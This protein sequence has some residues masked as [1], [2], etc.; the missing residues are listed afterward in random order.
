MGKKPNNS[1]TGGGSSNSAATLKRTALPTVKAVVAKIKGASKQRKVDYSTPSF[2]SPTLD[3]F[4]IFQLLV[5]TQSL[6]AIAADIADVIENRVRGILAGGWTKVSEAS[7][8]KQV[9][10]LFAIMQQVTQ[11]T[12]DVMPAKGGQSV[13]ND[14]RYNFI[15]KLAED[16]GVLP[17]AEA[18]ISPQELADMLRLLHADPATLSAEDQA[19][20][21][22]VEQSV[23]LFREHMV[24]QI[25]G[26][27]GDHVIARYVSGVRFSDMLDEVEVFGQSEREQTIIAEL[28]QQSRDVLKFTQASDFEF[29]SDELRATAAELLGARDP[30]DIVSAGERN[31]ACTQLANTLNDG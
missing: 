19:Y 31:L 17:D 15:K 16:T 14:K 8:Y 10:T 25:G 12:T 9:M 26:A 4:T 6:S 24:N 23:N 7:F 18:D 22:E 3:H 20:R 29:P 2:R 13:L 5:A 30:R 11:H 28:N 21:T 1:G 27:S